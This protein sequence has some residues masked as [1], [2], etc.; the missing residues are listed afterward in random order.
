[1]K[2]F[3]KILGLYGKLLNFNM[4]REI[5][6]DANADIPTTHFF[7]YKE[8][9]YP[10]NFD[11]FK[12]FSQYFNSD[13]PKA[14]NID[15]TD[16]KLNISESSI[17]DFIDYCQARK[18]TLT[19]EN[20]PTLHKL[21]Q[22]FQVPSLLSKTKE[23]ISTHQKDVVV[24]IMSMYQNDDNFN[25][26]EYEEIMSNDFIQYIN[27]DRLLTL[28]IPVLHR[29]LTKYLLIHKIQSNSNNSEQPPELIEFLFK[30]LDHFG[31]E[32]SVLFDQID[33]YGSNGSLI[34][35][36]LDGYS[37]KFDFSFANTSS[38]KTVFQLENEI[39]TREKQIKK[40]ISQSQ[41]EVA[42]VSKHV[43]DQIE[44]MRKQRQDEVNDRKEV[45]AEIPKMVAQE[46]ERLRKQHEEE[47]NDRKKIIAEIPRIVAQEVESMKKQH[48]EE[49]KK[50]DEMM[51][52][53]L[54][55]F[56]A[57]QVKY[58]EEMRKQRD[59]FDERMRKMSDQLEKLSHPG[60]ARLYHG[61]PCG[62]ISLLGDSV[63][64]SAEKNN[65]GNTISNLR[66]LDDNNFYNNFG[67]TPSSESDSIIKFDFGAHKRVE[68]CSYLI[69]TGGDGPNGDHPKAWR[70]EGSNDGQ[71]WTKLD[72]RS[73]DGRMNGSYNECHFI[74]KYGS[75]GSESNLFR[76]IRYVQEDS[77]NSNSSRK[78]IVDITYFELYGN[79]VTL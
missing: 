34:N 28:S 61:D 19:K 3:E 4:Q 48:E 13:Q 6:I 47:V 24:E 49:M 9:Q 59:D 14:E 79:V 21:S 1:M 27:D 70:I 58:Q 57:I 17:P 56:E 15:F 64:L 26:D 5:S 46:I 29:I 40:Q 63:T 50:K 74:C 36:L 75:N 68:L 42:K 8:K 73:N 33:L 16:E 38:L 45:F 41:E 77:W 39:I 25:L 30:C 32:A 7:V 67:P 60:I 10:F 54:K 55:Q 51:A 11:L 69:R 22:K 78:Y 65:T 12:I 76:Y 43:A 62:L 2:N 23:F 66:K 35:R 31:R 44:L 18:I 72:S 53:M 37:E 20:A 71:P 52:N